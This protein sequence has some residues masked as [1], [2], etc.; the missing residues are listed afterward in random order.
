[1]GNKKFPDT[2]LYTMLRKPGDRALNIYDHRFRV[3]D[4]S[5]SMVSDPSSVKK[6]NT[7][8]KLA[9]ATMQYVPY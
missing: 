2:V 5:G 7:T 8:F 4:L 9:T 6:A 3:S 1:M